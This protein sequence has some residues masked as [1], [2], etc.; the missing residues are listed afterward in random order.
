MEP[1]HGLPTVSCQELRKLKDKEKKHVIIDVRDLADYEAGHVE[2]SLHVPLKE[3]ESNIDA[4]VPDK[5]E[6]VIVIGE[7]RGLAPQTY[8]SLQEKGYSN[9]EFLLGGFDEWCKPATPDIAEL[10][11]DAELD[12]GM[13]EDTREHGEDKDDVEQGSD[14]EPLVNVGPLARVLLYWLA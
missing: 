2:D 4:V 12:K 7:E 9:V 1:S 13:G 14:D 5:D 3:L 10:V 8:A 6:Y 11:E